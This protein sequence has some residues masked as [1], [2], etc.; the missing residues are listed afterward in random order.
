MEPSTFRILVADD[1]EDIRLVLGKTLRTEGYQVEEVTNGLELLERA[2]EVVP[3]LIILDIMMPE[4]DG[5]SALEVI[6]GEEKLASCYVILLTGR[7]TLQEKLKGFNSGADDYITKPYSLVE[8]KARVRAGIRIKAMQKCLQGSLEIIVRQEKMATIGVLAAGLA[9]EF[10]NIMG[11][12]SGYAQL[13][14]NN[15]KFSDQWLRGS[16]GP[17]PGGRYQRRTPWAR[18]RPLHSGSRH[19]V[20]RCDDRRP[21][22]RQSH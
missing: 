7:S 15:P 14:K 6:R 17:G 2:R 21:V 13:A 8:L 1:H 19:V 16:R 12:I 10:N 4:L 3:D 22:P 20:H 18:R 9:H 11:G 5:L